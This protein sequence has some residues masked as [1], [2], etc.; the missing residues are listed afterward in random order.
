MM[1][2]ES[3]FAAAAVLIADQISKALVMS[4]TTTS[5]RERPFV[6]IQRPFSYGIA[7]FPLAQYSVWR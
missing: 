2:L 7:D 1:W 3:V 5:V 6:S 4:R